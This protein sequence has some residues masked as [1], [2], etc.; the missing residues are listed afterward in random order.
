MSFRISALA[1]LGFLAV[2]ASCS[3][4]ELPF[5]QYGE[6]LTLTESTSVSDVLADPEA[7]VGQNLRVEGTVT[8]VCERQGCWIA[9]AGENEGEQ[10]RVKVED[11]VIVFPQTAMGCHARVEGTLEKLELTMEQ[12]LAQARHHAEEQGLEFDPASVTGPEVIYQLRGLGAEIEDTPRA[13]S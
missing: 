7:Y 10:L 9:V 5:T 4:P 13:A 11:G 8:G 3:E 1:G 6:A 12:A 2:V